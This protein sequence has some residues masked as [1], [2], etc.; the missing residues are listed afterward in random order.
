MAQA[1]GFLDVEIFDGARLGVSD[2]YLS[3]PLKTQALCRYARDMG[4]ERL[5]KIDD[6]G[7]IRVDK[8]TIPTA[9]YAGARNVPNDYGWNGELARPSSPAGTHPYSY[10]NGGAY[11]LSSRCIHI[12]SEANITDWA[13]DRWVGNT[14]GRVGTEL[15]EIPGYKSVG[16]CNLPPFLTPETVILMQ[17]PNPEDLLTCH[18]STW[19]Y[20]F[21]PKPVVTRQVF[22]RGPR[23]HR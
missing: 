9:D 7:Y 13:E 23:R 8:L 4:Y 17:I 5:L 14:L 15:V 21:R 18:S 3:L 19:D 10:A 6:D 11:W 1:T 20:V 12:I 2:D 22:L 16:P